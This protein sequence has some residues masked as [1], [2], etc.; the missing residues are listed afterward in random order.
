MGMNSDQW[1]NGAKMRLREYYKS[2]EALN[3][4]VELLSYLRLLS[5]IWRGK[6]DMNTAKEDISRM[7][8][9]MSGAVYDLPFFTNVA[10]RV[11][12]MFQ[13]AVLGMLDAARY[14]DKIESQPG[15]DPAARLTLM[16][17]VS[18]T[19][20]LYREFAMACMVAEQGVGNATRHGLVLREAVDSLFK[21]E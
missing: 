14:V 15:M 19:S 16:E 5:L 21:M 6:L 11:M 12:P 2:D 7:M 17:N 13:A 9:G 10:P 1:K 8:V 4:V 18:S 20:K 3:F